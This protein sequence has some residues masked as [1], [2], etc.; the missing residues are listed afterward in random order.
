M[1]F[2]SEKP[3]IYFDRV[4]YDLIKLLPSNPDNKVLELGAGGGDTLLEIKTKN[5]AKEVAGIE[6][7]ELPGSN[8]SSKLIDRLIIANVEKDTIDLPNAYY[9]AILIGDVLEHLENPWKTV[10]DLS[11]HL[12]NGGVFIASIPN[13][14]HFTALYHIYV[15]GNFGYR[16][17]GL[18][19]KTHLRFFCKKNIIQLFTTPFSKVESIAS[20]EDVRSTK[21]SRR[22]IFN[23]ITFNLFEEFLA[24]QYIVVAR[25]I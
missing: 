7:M 5:L 6:L 23:K 20:I 18:F 2:Y 8:Q 22:K 3:V 13:I 1:N 4:R 24:F 21:L 14:R 19:D 17:E 15:K 25:K 10:S 9:D 12:K 16:K 11:K